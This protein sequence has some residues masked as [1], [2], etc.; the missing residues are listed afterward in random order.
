MCRCNV[1]PNILTSTFTPIT[2]TAG[3]SGTQQLTPSLKNSSILH[4][5]F[6]KTPCRQKHKAEE[7]KQKLKCITW[8]S[9]RVNACTGMGELVTNLTSSLVG[10]ADGRGHLHERIHQTAFKLQLLPQRS[11]AAVQQRRMNFTEAALVVLVIAG[12]LQQPDGVL[13]QELK[14]FA[15]LTLV[16]CCSW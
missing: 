15:Y 2:R 11:A 10:G 1:L 6:F 5:T 3:S 7:K 8:T 14:N 16:S 9:Q 4:L 12:V 13:E